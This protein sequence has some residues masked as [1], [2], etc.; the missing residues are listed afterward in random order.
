VIVPGVVVPYVMLEMPGIG[1][2]ISGLTPV[3]LVSTAP[4]GTLPPFRVKLELAPSVETEEAVPVVDVDCEDA[5]PEVELADP[6][7]LNPPPSKVE[8]TDVVDV[9]LLVPEIGEFEE[10]LAL[11]VELA[12]GL[13][14]PGSISVAPS[15]MPV[16][17]VPL[18][19]PPSEPSGEVVPNPD[20]VMEVC[21]L[22]IT[23][24]QNSTIAAI[25]NR[26]RMEI[27]W[28]LLRGPLCFA[29]IKGP[30]CIGSTRCKKSQRINASF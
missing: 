24:P 21:A 4:S 13:R 6:P 18:L 20:E 28:P 30:A 12:K 26:G 3:V 10:L 19:L 15:G 8:P 16:P 9:M 14:P 23:Q 1:T 2:V 27:L 5:Q 22:A 11:Q 17:L 29:S 7:A 25:D